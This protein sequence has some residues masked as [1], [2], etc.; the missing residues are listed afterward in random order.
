[1]PY[2]KR[3]VFIQTPPAL[4]S[5]QRGL[6]LI[7]VLLVLVVVAVLGVGAARMAMLGEKSTRYDRDHQVAWEAAEAALVD[8]VYDIN[9]V[10]TSSNDRAA[11]FPGYSGAKPTNMQNFPSGCGTSTG[12]TGTQGMCQPNA[13]SSKPLAYTVNFSSSHAVAFGTFTG[14]SFSAGSSGIQSAALPRYVIEI[15]PDPNSYSQINASTGTPPQLYI[16]RITA[17]GY[18][19]SAG[20]Q[21]VLQLVYRK[22]A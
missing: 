6:S 20:T 16:Y 5:R 14:R 21:V 13:Q 1:M 17:I 19:P 9:G 3:D 12:P 8:A 10:S 2:L 7:V 11:L 18:G 4:A 22:P 15:L